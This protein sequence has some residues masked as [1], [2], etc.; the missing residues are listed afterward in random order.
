MPCIEKICDAFGISLAMF[1]A[2]DAQERRE[3]TMQELLA[4]FDGL[5]EE[6]QDALIDVAKLLQR[7]K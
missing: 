6:Q 4:V 1:F 7:N 3:A 5:N 2:E